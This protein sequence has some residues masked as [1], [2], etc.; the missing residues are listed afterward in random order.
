MPLT[1]TQRPNGYWYVT[2]TVT[3]WRNGEPD[4]IEVRRS[5][6]TKDE[7]IADGIRR[8]IENAAAEQ[9]VTN[10]K[11][12]LSFQEAAERYVK[13]GGDARFLDKPKHYLG[14][15][16]VDMISQQDIDDAAFKAYPTQAPATRRRQFY[17]PA[18]AVL[19]S[20]GIATLYKRPSGGQK[21]TIFFHPDKAAELIRELGGSRWPNPW[22]PALANFLFCQGSRVG[23]TLAI[24]GK[25]DVS[26]AGRYVVLRDTK[27]DK[28]RMVV[29]TSR[30]VAALSQIPNLG[31]SGPLFLRYDGR[32]YAE[33]EGR[34]YRLRAWENAVER[35]G[36]DPSEFT[37]HTA[38]H[39]WATWFYAVT[40]DVVRLRKEGGWDSAEWERYVKLA[41]PEIAD[42]ALRHGF[43]EMQNPQNRDSV[44]PL[45]VI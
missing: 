9:S 33:R 8:Q 15:M 37:P 16:R 7:S 1:L 38:R 30:T 42:A 18:I 26:L 35:V 43:I 10:R 32:P 24:D 29:L 12:V 14:S 19:R 17:T 13:H 3:V 2:G 21:R 4:T 34:G 39:S 28:E 5:T 41:T 45:R 44:A 11:P 22:T 31:R 25:R 40:K 27:S 20:A 23:E 36:L 6:K